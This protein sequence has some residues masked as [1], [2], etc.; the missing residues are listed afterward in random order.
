MR[1]IQKCRKF[2]RVKPERFSFRAF[3]VIRTVL[4]VTIGRYFSRAASFMT[5]IMMYQST[6]TEWNPWVLFDGSLYELGLD[7]KNFQFMILMIILL[8]LLDFLKEKGYNLRETVARQGIVF[9]WTIYILAILGVVVFG[10]YGEGFD[11][12]NFIYQGF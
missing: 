7:Q 6:F 9:R 10:M 5:A 1:Y 8:F 4:I 12:S 2:F 11:A 3:Q